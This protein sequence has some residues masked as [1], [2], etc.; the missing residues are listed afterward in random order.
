MNKYTNQIMTT[1]SAFKMDGLGNDFLII[2]R[3]I[4]NIHLSKEKIIELTD[5]KKISFDQIIFLEKEIKNQTPITIF[6]SDGNEVAACGNGSR[7]VGYLLGKEKNSNNV[8]LKTTERTLA[9]EIVGDLMVKI[10]MGKP[11][12][13]WKQIPLSKELD[14]KKINIKIIDKNNNKYNEGFALNVGNPHIIFFVKNC[15]DFYLKKLGPELENHPLFPEKCNVTLA[16]VID[17]NNITVNVWERGAGLTKACGTAACAAAIS[18]YLKN[19]T[20]RKCNIIFKQGILNINFDQDE[21]IFMTG[22]VSEV[23]KIE[24]NI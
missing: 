12:F 16:Q 4:T 2:D 5:R 1:I 7:C 14:H 22:P 8:L 19:L 11:L 23:K 13:G 9:A 21:N 17:K 15:F 10:N 20:D 24:I 18:G 6:N 3:R